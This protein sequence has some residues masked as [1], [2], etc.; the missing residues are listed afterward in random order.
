MTP[1]QIEAYVDATA[2]ALA[3]PLEAAHRPGVLSY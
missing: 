2:A 3:L 1:T